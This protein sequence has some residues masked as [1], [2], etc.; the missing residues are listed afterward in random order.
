M[1]YMINGSSV[2]L[3]A[4]TTTDGT[5][6]VPVAGVAEALGGTVEWKHDAKTA[7]VEIGGKVAFIQP[8]NA[9]V[10]L[11][12]AALD[13][14]ANPYLDGDTLMVPARLFRDGFGTSLSVDGDTVHIAI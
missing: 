10:S 3:I 14:K 7:R 4:P 11:D 2:E 12:G 8:D 1:P 5:T 13:V 9:N 6:F